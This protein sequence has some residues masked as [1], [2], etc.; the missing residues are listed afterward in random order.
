MQDFEQGKK[1]G[2]NFAWRPCILIELCWEEKKTWARVTALKVIIQMREEAIRVTEKGS[3][4]VVDQKRGKT[5][6][7]DHLICAQLNN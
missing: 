2:Q 3:I 7:G 5:E 1:C 4:N 6:L